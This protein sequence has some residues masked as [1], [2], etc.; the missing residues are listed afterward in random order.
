MNEVWINDMEKDEAAYTI[1]S[2]WKH[3]KK[4]KFSKKR[5][6]IEKKKRSIVRI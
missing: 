6:K 1:Q 2:K 5:R 3:R 4:K